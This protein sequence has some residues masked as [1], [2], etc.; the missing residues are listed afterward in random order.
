MKVKILSK[1]NTSLFLQ[2][3]KNWPQNSIPKIK[4]LKIYEI[5]KDKKLLSY[6]DFSVIQI[7]DIILPFVGSEELINFFPYVLVDMGAIKF[8]CN[9]AKLMRPG[10]IHFE[11]FNK[12]DIVVIKDI[13]HRKALAVGIAIEDSITAETLSKGH[14]INNLH[15]VGDKF[16]TLY[17]E[18]KLQ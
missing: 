6:S 9:G 10:I 5:E 3:L 16:W 17:K 4:N 1:S 13:D 15:Y 2:E 12:N 8:V 18:I 11:S 14:I 7:S